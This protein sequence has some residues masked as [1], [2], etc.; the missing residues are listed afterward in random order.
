[1]P[2]F[3]DKWVVDRTL[4]EF[5]NGGSCA[6]CGFPHLFPDGVAGMINAISDLETDAAQA[7]IKA[8]EKSPWPPEMREQVWSDR[9]RL[10]HKLKKEMAVY[11]QFWDDEGEPF[12]H[13][14]R[15][16]ILPKR[17]RKFLQMPRSEVTERLRTQYGIHSAFGIVLCAVVEQVAHFKDTKYPTDARGD[18]EVA[19]EQTLKFDRRGGFIM[20]VSD[21]E[22]NYKEQVL[23]VWFDRMKTLGG[24]KLLDRTPKPV[25][26]DEEEGEADDALHDEDTSAGPSFRAD[27]RIV[28]LLVARYW[29]DI[30]IAKYKAAKKTEE[31]QPE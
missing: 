3:S 2:K 21:K 9:V 29:A 25:D 1:M 31:V 17:L 11:K 4:F 23:Q 6:C 10:R 7:E 14:I 24:P 26:D 20:R 19:F 30:M 22:G 16:E 28:R 5:V 8:A 13:W 12:Q 18:A 27:R 15:S